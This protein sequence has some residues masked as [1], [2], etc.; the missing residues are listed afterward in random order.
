[1]TVIDRGDHLARIIQNGLICLENGEKTVAQVKASEC[2]S[3]IGEQDL[4]VLG[5]KSHQ[6]MCLVRDLTAIVGPETVLLTTQNGIPW[7]YFFK[8]GGPY[9]GLRLESVDPGG[10]IADTL[11][12]DQVIPCI[13]YA[14]AEIARPGVIRKIEGNRFSI[15]EIDGSKSERV[16]RISVTFEK[17]GLRA[18]VVRDIRAE[19][20]TKLWGNLSFNPI[21]A[22]THATLED[23][24]KFSPTRDLAA[25]MMGEA[26]AIAEI[27][28]VRFR[29]SLEKRIAGAEAI[30]PHKTSMLQD[31]ERGERLEVDA[32]LGSVIELGRVVGVATPHLD[33]IY[34]IVKLLDRSSS[35]R[36]KPSRNG[37]DVVSRFTRSAE[38]RATAIK[39]LTCPQPLHRPRQYLLIDHS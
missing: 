11:P 2:I 6:I 24:C 17:A 22:L 18:P 21:T 10:I 32:L 38:R 39:V 27:L 33:S 13:V 4:I 7:W 3:D 16:Q 30:G 8:H 1:M 37:A 31:I 28:G 14:A 26:Q 15:A 35:K 9:E 5:V 29:I 34:A 23:A 25:A 12:I 36:G 20:W 19:I